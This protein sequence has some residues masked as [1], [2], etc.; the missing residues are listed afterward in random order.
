MTALN[1]MELRQSIVN[2]GKKW[3]SE[4]CN[5]KVMAKEIEKAIM[6]AH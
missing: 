5:E 2:R 6:D 1:D 3:L 4:R